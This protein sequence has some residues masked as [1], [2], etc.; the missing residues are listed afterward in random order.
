MK[1]KPPD[2]NRM[3]S[4]MQSVITHPGGIQQGVAS[5]DARQNIDVTLEGL[6]QVVTRS[7]ALTGAER[8]AIYGRAYHARL[9][10]C[11]RVEFPCLLHALGDKLFNHFVIDYLQH[12]PSQ[13]YTLH[14]LAENF[15]SYLAETRPDATAPPEERESWPDFI[16]DLATLERAFMEVYDGPGVE[17]QSLVNPVEVAGIAAER[18]MEVCFVP[19]PCLRLL[20]F[21]YPVRA[22]FTAVREKQ[23]PDLPEPADTFLAMTRQN[24]VVRFFELSSVQYQFLRALMTNLSVAQSIQQAAEATSDDYKSLATIAGTWLCDWANDGFFL[25]VNYR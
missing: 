1:E 10:E 15:P 14:R 21:R 11:F 2:L 25:R 17:G 6:E 13:S 5:D 19:V 20:A 3:Q 9:L 18:L 4:W 16:I 8:L 23:K 7:E 24:Y 22:Y 12:Y